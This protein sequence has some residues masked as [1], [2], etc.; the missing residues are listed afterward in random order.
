MGGQEW[1]LEWFV[2]IDLLPCLKQLSTSLRGLPLIIDFTPR[3]VSTIPEDGL[4]GRPQPALHGLNA[5]NHCHVIWLS[6]CHT[7]CSSSYTPWMLNIYSQKNYQ[8]WLSILAQQTT[9]SDPQN[10]W[11]LTLWPTTLYTM[12]A[13]K[14]WTSALM[15]I[16]TKI[17]QKLRHICRQK[18]LQKIFTVQIW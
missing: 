4:T 6:D 15:Q 9:L 7:R 13:D 17:V 11:P 10:E 5:V 14:S 3:P 16:Q 18:N 12:W 1:P 2:I 8:A